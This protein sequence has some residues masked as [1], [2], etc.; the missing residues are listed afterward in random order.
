METARRKSTYRLRVGGVCA[1][2]ERATD[3]IPDGAVSVIVKFPFLFFQR[4]D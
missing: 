2:S 4:I 3:H 1:A